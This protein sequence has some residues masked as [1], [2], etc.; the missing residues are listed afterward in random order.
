MENSQNFHIELMTQPGT[1]VADFITQKIRD[2]NA[3]HWT[4]PR[5]PLAT[6][7]RDQAGDI[8]AGATARTFGRWLQIDYFWVAE[9]LR[10]QGAGSQLL[11]QLEDEARRR[12]CVEAVLDTLDFQARPFYEKH[13]Y[14]V[15]WTMTCYPESGSRHYMTKQL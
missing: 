3:R 13:G 6:V 8:I 9:C 5:L 10:G 14:Q 12:G 4:V 1:D 15:Q 7:I 2:F 11:M